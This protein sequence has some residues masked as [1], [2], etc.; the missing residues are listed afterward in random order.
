MISLG[1]FESSLTQVPPGAVLIFCVLILSS[2]FV[3]ED[4]ILNTTNG[5]VNRAY[6]DELWE[7]ALLKVVAILRTH[8]VGIR[9]S[10]V[11]QVDS[12]LTPC[13]GHSVFCL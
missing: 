11:S 4:H 6:I 7:M 12:S 8:I 9:S 5:L 2:F 13:N 10:V 3:V 1:E